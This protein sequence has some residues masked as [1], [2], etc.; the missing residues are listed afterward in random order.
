MMSLVELDSIRFVSD[1]DV[2]GGDGDDAGLSYC[3]L[4]AD[5]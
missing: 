1:V 2:D 5:Y 3:C 4:L